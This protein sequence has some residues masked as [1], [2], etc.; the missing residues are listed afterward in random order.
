MSATKLLKRIL[1]S[2]DAD[3][4][5]ASGI[6]L[7][8]VHDHTF[9]ISS[10][11]ITQFAVVFSALVHDVGHSGVANQRLAIEEPQ[12]A[13][14]YKNQSIA[15]RRSLDIA[16]Q[17]LQQSRFQN[18]RKSIYGDEQECVRFRHV[19]VNSVL[20]TDIFDKQ[21]SAIRNARWERA[22]NKTGNVEKLD[23]DDDTSIKATIV[24]E[25]IILASDVAHT[26]QH[27]CIYQKWNERLFLEMNQAYRAG[28][29]DKD[30]SEG[31]YNGELWFFDNYIIPLANKLKECGVFGVNSEEYLHYACQNRQE[32]ALKGHTVVGEM[33][34]RASKKERRRKSMQTVDEGNEDSFTSERMPIA[35]PD[36]RPTGTVEDLPCESDKMAIL[37]PDSTLVVADVPAKCRTV[38]APPGKLL[39]VLNTS[40]RG[41]IRVDHIEPLS[42]LVGLLQVGEYIVSIDDEPTINMPVFDVGVLLNK[43]RDRRLQ[44]VTD[45]EV[46][47]TFVDC[48]IEI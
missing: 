41:L 11:P 29:S 39:I 44:V 33:T 34:H 2:D 15:E 32:W 28:R 47:R 5:C 19:V 13:E 20:A 35:E 23:D 17:I 22:F 24:L 45:E 9:G 27:F 6:T 18:L 1:A 14:K 42:P 43:N 10:D 8:E 7:K 30:P 25:Q 4:K 46:A 36:C 37:E 16:F 26:M 38:V 3:Q 12:I 21:L 31:W 48:L 40:E